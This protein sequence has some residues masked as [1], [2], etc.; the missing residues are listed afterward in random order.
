MGTN[1]AFWQISMTCRSFW[2]D[3]TQ[4]LQ[5][6]TNQSHERNLPLVGGYW[7]FRINESIS[8]LAVV[9]FFTLRLDEGGSEE[10]VEFVNGIE[11]GTMAAWLNAQSVEL[12]V[13][14][15]W[16]VKTCHG[17]FLIH[18]NWLVVWNIFIFPFSWACHHP[19]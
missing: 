4:T 15:S 14:T 6:C 2:D 19:N 3:S 13:V 10:L 18:D 12:K 16:F 1:C 5:E 11:D 7:D 9:P 8:S 17:G